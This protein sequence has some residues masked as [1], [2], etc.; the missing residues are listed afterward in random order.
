MFEMDELGYMSDPE[1]T[2]KWNL[3]LKLNSK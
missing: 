3:K 1:S 2:K